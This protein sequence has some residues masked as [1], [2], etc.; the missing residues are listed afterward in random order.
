MALPEQFYD[1]YNLVTNHF[2]MR[3]T[4]PTVALLYRWQRPAEQRIRG[5]AGRATDMF[6][7]GKHEDVRVVP[8]M[9]DWQPADIP[10][11]D[12]EDGNWV[13]YNCRH[14]GAV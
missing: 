10:Q 1:V 9:S 6:G 8:V 7:N 3:A 2:V 11:F 13:D 12:A 5:N 14:R 4:L